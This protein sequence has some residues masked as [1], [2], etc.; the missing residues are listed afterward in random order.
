MAS[1]APSGNYMDAL[2]QLSLQRQAQLMMSLY[3]VAKDSV[4]TESSPLRSITTAGEVSAG[5]VD[6]VA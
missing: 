5:K 2:I 6:I 4:V 3:Q 1:V